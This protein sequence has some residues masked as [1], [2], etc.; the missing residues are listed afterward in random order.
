MNL[1]LVP[2]ALRPVGSF[3][4]ISHACLGQE[5]EALQMRQE[6]KTLNLILRQLNWHCLLGDQHSQF[7]NRVFLPACTLKVK[8]PGQTG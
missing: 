8:R 4:P 3:L 1:D 2:S 7:L 6:M 5:A